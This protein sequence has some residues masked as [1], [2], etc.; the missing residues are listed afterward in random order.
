[1]TQAV[2]RHRTSYPEDDIESVQPPS[3]QPQSLDSNLQQP[4]TEKNA[5]LRT[6]WSKFHGKGEKKISI[7]KSLKAIAFCSWLNIF[8]IFLPLGWLS[9]FKVAMAEKHEEEI[10]FWSTTTTFTCRFIHLFVLSYIHSLC[11][12]F[13]GYHALAKII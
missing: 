10:R 13:S 2:P 9:H 5:A 4:S 6:S 1:M 11:S 3:S 12:L 8:F 7:R